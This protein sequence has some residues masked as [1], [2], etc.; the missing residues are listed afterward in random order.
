[1]ALAKLNTDHSMTR[2]NAAECVLAPCA[3]GKLASIANSNMQLIFGNHGVV[4]RP[5]PI[6]S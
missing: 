1:M 5:H 2:S 4:Q 3:C 6:V